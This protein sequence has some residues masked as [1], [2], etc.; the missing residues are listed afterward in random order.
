MHEKTEYT[1]ARSV[2]IYLPA[3]QYQVIDVQFVCIQLVNK[4]ET[5]VA[6]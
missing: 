5:K 4:E 6:L 1:S 2:I 3:S